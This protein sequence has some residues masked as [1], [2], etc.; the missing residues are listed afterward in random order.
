VSCVHGVD[1]RIAGRICRRQR[2]P[3]QAQFREDGASLVEREVRE[4]SYGR[5]VSDTAA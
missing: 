2:F 5:H 3:P 1:L 4:L